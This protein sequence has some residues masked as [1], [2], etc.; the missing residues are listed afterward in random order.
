MRAAF[1]PVP[2]RENANPAIGQLILWRGSDGNT[3][4]ARVLRDIGF[5]NYLVRDL[6]DESTYEIYDERITH[7]GALP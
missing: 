6:I 4:V 5:A 1:I 7:K 2:K 3:Y